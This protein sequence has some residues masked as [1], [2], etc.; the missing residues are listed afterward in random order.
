VAGSLRSHTLGWSRVVPTVRT[1]HEAGRRWTT[2]VTR[3]GQPPSNPRA[4]PEQPPSNPRATTGNRPGLAENADHRE[5]L[6]IRGIREVSCHGH[7][8]LKHSVSLV[9]AAGRPGERPSGLSAP[10]APQAAAPPSA[11]VAAPALCALQGQMAQHLTSTRSRRPGHEAGDF[12]C[13][14]PVAGQPS[15]RARV[16]VRVKVLSGLGAFPGVC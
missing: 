10:P 13:W 9:T 8:A 5:V 16:K 11:A 15:T 6:H 1:R 4:T 12:G 2:F 14:L 7:L 3:C